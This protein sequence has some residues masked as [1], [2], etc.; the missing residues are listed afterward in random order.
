MTRIEWMNANSYDIF[1]ARCNVCNYFKKIKDR[2][3]NPI[4][5]ACRL[6]EKETTQDGCYNFVAQTSYC[7]RF[8]NNSGFFVEPVKLII[9]AIAV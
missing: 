3:I 7:D 2:H 9:P 8:T 1:S 5:G 4:Y 6:M